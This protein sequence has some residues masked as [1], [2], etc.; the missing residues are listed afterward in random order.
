MSTFRL[1]HCD[2]LKGLAIIGIVLQHEG[3]VLV[4][5]NLNVPVFF[6]LAGFFFREER[7]KLIIGKRACQL[8]VPYLWFVL[9]FFLTKCFFYY[10]DEHDFI[11]TLKKTIYTVNIFKCNVILHKSIWFLLVLFL[12]SILYRII[13]YVNDDW[14]IDFLVVV[15][16]VVGYLV[17][18][19]LHLPVI[20]LSDVVLSSTLFFHAG[21]LLRRHEKSFDK[22]RWFWLVSSLLIWCVLTII[23][24][25]EHSYKNNKY[26]IYLPLMIIPAIFSFYCVIKKLVEN[27]LHQYMII[28]LLQKAGYFSLGILGYHALCNIIMDELNIDNMIDI[29][30]LPYIRVLVI[31]IIV[32]FLIFLSNRYNPMLIGKSK[33]SILMSCG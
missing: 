4:T 1:V 26:P 19:M 3:F 31:L 13:R 10:L 5:E 12:L 24:E 33:Q 29:N 17:K 27:L 28:I 9:L 32:P 21:Y 8:L 7:I 20:Y 16:F 14:L 30:Y 22:I 18:N 23:Y 15:V 25:P 2:L 11:W 6:I